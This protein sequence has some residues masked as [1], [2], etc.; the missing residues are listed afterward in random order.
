MEKSDQCT[1]WYIECAKKRNERKTFSKTFFIFIPYLVFL[2]KKPFSMYL[3][4]ELDATTVNCNYYSV[5]LHESFFSSPS[6]K[7]EMAKK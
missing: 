6:Q 4:A 1:Q 3:S 5:Q 7:Q 2:I